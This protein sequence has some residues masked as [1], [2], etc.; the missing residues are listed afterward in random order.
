MYENVFTF[1]KPE[2][3]SICKYST[4]QVIFRINNLSFF[5]NVLPVG[6]IIFSG[7]IKYSLNFMIIFELVE[8]KACE[9]FMIIIIKSVELEGE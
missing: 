4:K 9:K 5:F 6:F 2:N 8:L 7:L 3:H 1:L